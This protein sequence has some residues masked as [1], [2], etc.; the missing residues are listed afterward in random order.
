MH[1]RFPRQDG[2]MFSYHPAMQWN[3]S[4]VK[5]DQ[6]FCPKWQDS[7]RQSQRKRN[8]WSCLKCSLVLWQLASFASASEDSAIWWYYCYDCWTRYCGKDC[9]KSILIRQKWCSVF[10]F[11]LH[12]PNKQTNTFLAPSGALIAIPTYYWP[13]TPLFQ[14]TPVLNTGLSLSEPLQLYKGYNAI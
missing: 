8:C 2:W 14:I 11:P 3:C 1:L 10:D 6:S 5:V 7:Q 4:H 12:I 9:L 13:S